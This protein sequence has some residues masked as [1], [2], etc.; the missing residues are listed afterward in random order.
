MKPIN[1]RTFTR[2][3]FLKLSATLGVGFIAYKTIRFNIPVSSVK[4]RIAI[5]GGGA[6]GISMAARLQRALSNP[7]ITL[8]DPSETHYYQPGFTLIGSGVYEASQVHKPEES[9]IPSGVKW[10]KDYVVELDPDNNRLTTSQNGVIA[11]DFMVL[12]PGLQ[13]HFDEIEGISR[14]T[15]GTGN[16]HCIYDFN[17]AQKCWSAIKELSQKGG[18]AIFSDTWT[19]LKCGGAPKKINMMA[20]DYCRRQ[21]TRER[22]NFQFISASEKMFDVPLFCKRLEEIYFERHIP[23]TFHHRIKAVDTTARKVY[24]EHTTDDV[25]KTVSHDYDFLHIV[26][27]MSAPNFVRQ[28]PLAVNP[29]TGKLENWVPTDKDTLI[30]ARYR[31]VMVLGDV[32]GIPTSKTG[33]AIRI[34]IPVAVANLIS[35]VEN[36]TPSEVYNG[37]TACPFVTEHGK[38]LMAEFGYD[39][40]PTPS[41][42]LLDPGKEH[43]A[44]WFLKTRM[45]KPMYFQ[46]M[47][48]GLC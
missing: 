29:Q 42:P 20:E 23:I 31:N 32:A 7:D 27:P 2:R 16:A 18:Q 25:V 6:A 8:I 43:W 46:G 17:G 21:G 41:M 44:G 15:L 11:Y 19:K 37:Y 14:E 36:E 9:L 10:L 22:V 34:Q 47:L 40:I 3:D 1:K 13:M 4:A 48:R 26:P 35:L 33:A 45:L 5:V 24:F 12:C 28:S 38:V 30:H 39:K